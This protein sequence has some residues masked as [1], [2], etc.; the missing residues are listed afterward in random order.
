MYQDHFGF[1]SPPFRES[2]GPAGLVEL[3]SRRSAIRRLRYGIEHGGGPALLFGPP[4][5]GKTAVASMLAREVG[6]RSV[7]LSY[8]AMPA[9]EL[10]AFLADELDGLERASG[11]S[12][13]GLHA[14]L[15]RLRSKLDGPAGRGRPTLLVV[16][17]AHLIDDP[18]TFEAL[19]LLQNVPTAGPPGL[20][21]LIVG[22]PEVLLKIPPGLD[23]RL[24]ARVA[25]GPLSDPEA[26]AYLRGR[27][28]AAGAGASLFDPP[29]AARL[30]LLADGLPRRLNRLAD[31]A[32][33][34]AFAEG[35]PRPDDRCLD[36]A[37]QEADPDLQAA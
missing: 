28:E 14:T 3:P 35:L 36:H 34:I 1:D 30:N 33:L 13:P 12:A 11:A 10:L 25:L 7:H 2:I 31:L 29:Q 24:S 5:S 21:L 18:A 9:D 15:R 37:A 32:L 6:G 22:A 23:D 17:E 4:G 19:R 20:M 8:P 26:E 27:F 16:D